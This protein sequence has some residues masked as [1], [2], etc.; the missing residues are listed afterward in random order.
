MFAGVH[1]MLAVSHRRAEAAGLHGPAGLPDAVL[2]VVVLLRQLA[3]V[4]ES[5]SDQQYALKPVGVVSSSIGGHVRHSLD[6]LEEL[7]AGLATGAIDY[8]R[9]QRGTDVERCRHA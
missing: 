8:D 7:L 9:R 5:L 1:R 6:H 3:G 2:P 4:L